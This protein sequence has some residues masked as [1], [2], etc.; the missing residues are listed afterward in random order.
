M[1]LPLAFAEIVFVW[2]MR[3]SVGVLQVSIPSATGLQFRR[4]CDGC[5]VFPRLVG[6]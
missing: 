5:D 4:L 2:W 6:H 1:T 3:S